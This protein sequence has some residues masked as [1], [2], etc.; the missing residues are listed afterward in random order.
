MPAR[1]AI[2]DPPK[3]STRTGG[4][5]TPWSAGPSLRCQASARGCRPCGRRRGRGRAERR[6]RSASAYSWGPSTGVQRHLRPRRLQLLQPE[7]SPTISTA[8]SK[9]RSCGGRGT[10][11][12]S[13]GHM[14][15]REAAASAKRMRSCASISPERNN[16]EQFS[17]CRSLPD[18]MWPNQRQAQRQTR[19]PRTRT[20]E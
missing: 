19:L 14:S 5:T 4:V 2:Q 1:S 15:A 7:P 20:A 18:R 13:R 10:R 17:S 16:H 11:S 9:G 6:A 8:P 12:S 3:N